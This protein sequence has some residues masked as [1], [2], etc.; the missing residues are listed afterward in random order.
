MKTGG[1]RELTIPASLAYGDKASGDIPA[2]STLRF[3]VFIIDNP[4]QPDVPD[5]LVKL[6]ERVN[7]Q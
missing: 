7:G 3:I 2:N 5:D 4:N 1:V 6:Y